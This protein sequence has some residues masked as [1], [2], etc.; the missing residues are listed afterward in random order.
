M[1]PVRRKISSLSPQSAFPK[2]IPGR[3]SCSPGSPESSQEYSRCNSSSD[4]EK[5]IDTVRWSSQ[6]FSYWEDQ[7]SCVMNLLLNTL[8]F[9]NTSHTGRKYSNTSIGGSSI[10]SALGT[11][12][13]ASGWFPLRSLLLLQLAIVLR[14]RTMDEAAEDF[15]NHVCWSVSAVEFR[16]EGISK[17]VLAQC[18]ALAM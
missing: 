16:I 18:P 13:I 5:R 6:S 1:F 9:P 2:K 7:N 10:H 17:I 14:R 15:V 11:R 8:C 12:P 4:I 3:T